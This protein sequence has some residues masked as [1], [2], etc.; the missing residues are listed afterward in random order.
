[1][2]LRS[3]PA[4]LLHSPYETVLFE[5][6]TPIGE[7]PF[8]FALSLTTRLLAATA[9]VTALALPGALAADS[10]TQTTVHLQAGASMTDTK[11]AACGCAG[12]FTA[13]VALSCLAE[14]FDEI[15]AMDRL[16]GFVSLHGP[17]FYRLPV[18]DETVTRER[19]EVA[20][21][22]EL[23]L[24]GQTIVPWHGGQT[25]GWKFVGLA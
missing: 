10:H 8:M 11:E 23:P 19:V 1:M 25:I 24:V 6:Y 13:P 12:C 20:V 16:E 2:A 14:V 21:P 18:N 17:A 9:S 3:F 4:T 5:Q 22:E 15:D 7:E